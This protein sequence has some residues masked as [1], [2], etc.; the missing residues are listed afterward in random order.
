MIIYVINDEKTTLSIDTYSFGGSIQT[1]QR[2]NCEPVNDR[3]DVP[4]DS[5]CG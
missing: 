2:P 5:C 1:V 4:F 3:D